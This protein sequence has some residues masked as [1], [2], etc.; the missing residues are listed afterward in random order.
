M[1]GEEPGERLRANAVG[2]PGVVFMVLAAVAPMAAVVAIV[3]LGIA[4]GN[5]GGMPGAVLLVGVCLGCFA[6]G[7][8]AMSRHV[9]NAGAFY[10][11][12]SRGL[13]R[14]LGIAAAAVA[15]VSYPAMA[16][17]VTGAFGF[18]GGQAFSSQLGIDLP[19]YLWSLLLLTAVGIFGYLEINLSAKV[20]GVALIL[21]MI[22]IL[23]VDIGIVVQHGLSAFPL[24][25]LSPSRVL[26]AAPGIA[27]LYGFTLF[28]GFEAT[29]IF[30]EESRDPQRTVGRATYTAV[31]IIAVFY[32]LTAW[33]MIGH[34]G[35]DDVQGVATH[36][37]GALVFAS[38]E[39]NT[40][41][42][43]VVIMEWLMLSSA[44]AAVLALHNSASR[45]LFALGRV[46]LLP[47]RLGRSHRR[48]GSPHIASMVL[49][50]VELSVVVVCAQA[51]VDPYLQLAALASA[52]ATFGII[53]LQV[54]AA[55]SVVGFFW[56]RPDRSWLRTIVL[57]GIGA[58][59]LL[60]A[61]VLIVH[62]FPTL[63]GR[64]SGVVN[65]IP[66]FVVG[67]A[68]LALAYGLWLRKFRSDR[69]AAIA[70]ALETGEA[71][72]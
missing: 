7:Y 5:G 20:L 54:G 42:W 2:V 44:A 53:L 56:R 27:L 72:P 65:Q 13:G 61:C 37:P 68:G 10:A 28:V 25:A 49:S 52:L 30:S 1:S 50:A 62:N 35:V 67:L 40:G 58:A 9:V 32:M 31:F 55:A 38:A 3:P 41:R 48:F 39:A 70:R 51:A 24:E 14:P 22:A 4:F 23:V 12:I 47:R 16:L 15:V 64:P 63:T 57:P 11:Y 8:V 36:D 21:E 45:Y 69:Y 18:F 59:G 66:W 71:Q 19:W 6:V 46:R 26:G 43:L 29:A 34:F 33:L 60:G 17:S